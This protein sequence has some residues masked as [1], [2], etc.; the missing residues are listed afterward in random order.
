MSSSDLISISL[1]ENSEFGTSQSIAAND[2][3]ER[4]MLEIIDLK[5]AIKSIKA[6]SESRTP[7]AGFVGAALSY[8]NKSTQTHTVQFTLRRNY[9]WEQF[10]VSIS[11]RQKQVEFKQLVISSFSKRCQKFIDREN[12]KVLF[13]LKTLH[14]VENSF[15]KLEK[16]FFQFLGKSTNLIMNRN[17]LLDTVELLKTSIGE[18]S[19]G[20]DNKENRFLPSELKNHTTLEVEVSFLKRKVKA[21]EE[22]NLKVTKKLNQSVFKEEK[23]T[24]EL[25]YYKTLAKA[26]EKQNKALKHKLGKKS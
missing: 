3:K 14:R 21:L 2:E 4:L 18:H 22:K 19:G 12:L 15:T 20:I 9:K 11:L 23:T 8:S 6:T 1:E 24:T 13:L 26:L 16:L 7:D 5:S 17:I 10:V 25:G